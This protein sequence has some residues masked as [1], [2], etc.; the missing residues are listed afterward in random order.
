MRTIL[1]LCFA[2]LLMSEVA[3]IAKLS[4][5]FESSFNW[6]LGLVLILINSAIH[7]PTQPPPAD[8]ESMIL[9]E[10]SFKL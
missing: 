2:F 3:G 5:N 6:G 4:P 9:T 10:F 7:Q 8:R 1:P